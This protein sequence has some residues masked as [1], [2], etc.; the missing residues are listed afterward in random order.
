[1]RAVQHVNDPVSTETVNGIA[2]ISSLEEENDAA[3]L[4]TRVLPRGSGNGGAVL[5]LAAATASAPS[6]YTLDAAQNYIKQNA[7]ETTY[8]RIERVL[9]FKDIGPV[10][11][12][13]ADIQAAAN[14]LMVASLEYLRRYS[15]PQKFY[16]VELAYSGQLLI[17]GTLVRVIY[18]SVV[19]GVLQYDLNQD[20]NILKVDGQI[21][22]NG[23]HTQAISISTIDRMPQTDGDFLASQAMGARVFAAHQ[24]LGPSVDTLTWRDEMDNTHGSSFPFWCGDEYTTIQRA[25]L[26]FKIQ[27]LRSTVKSVGASSATSSSGGGGTQTSSSGGG[28]TETSAGGGG[29]T[30][31]AN[32]S[33][34]WTWSDSSIQIP[35]GGNHYHGIGST[36]HSHPVY[37][38]DHTHD[39]SI[40]GHAH[41]VTIPDH[42]HDVTP[43]LTT[44]Y[45]I[46]EESGGNTLALA[47]LVIRLNG[48]A[49]LRASVVS[50]SGGWYE[51]DITP[52]LVDSVYRPAQTANAVEITTSTAK[53][54]RIE[55]Q[56]T[57]RG[58]VQAVNYE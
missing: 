22:S 2:V 48:G 54:A 40:P 16:R 5:T 15:A 36:Q 10:S 30:W 32:D 9:D 8:G 6:G 42:T 29:G 45:G 38:S 18:R 14:T 41:D 47:D 39:V 34:S 13:K 4:L 57:I 56:L 49:D 23:I 43:S 21:D 28:G 37:T 12:T 20:F 31:T 25:V 58:V 19:N 44:T 24:Q 3:E 46:Y 7:A 50:L 52:G 1:V 27:P 17:P 11:N 26:R 51:L 33:V 53:T 55:A 35:S